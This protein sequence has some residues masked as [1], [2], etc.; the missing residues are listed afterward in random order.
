M[1]SL[2]TPLPIRPRSTTPAVVSG[3]VLALVGFIL[4]ATAV[5]TGA[6]EGIWPSTAFVG[7]AVPLRHSLEGRA[8]EPR[9]RPGWLLVSV[10]MVVGGVLLAVL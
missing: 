3:A 6:P 5:A 7:A 2:F 4:L 9:A 10:A 1:M 8:P